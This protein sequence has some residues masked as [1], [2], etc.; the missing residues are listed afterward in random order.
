MV[1]AKALPMSKNRKIAEVAVPVP[2][3]NTFHYRVPEGLTDIISLGQRVLVPFGSRRLAGHVIGFPETSELKKLKE[4]G[5]I[6]DREPELIPDILELCRWASDYYVSP[7]GQVFKSALV[8]GTTQTKK[9]ACLTE[10]GLNYLEAG[11]ED[12]TSSTLRLIARRGSVPVQTLERKLGRSKLRKL[13]SEQLISLEQKLFHHPLK[14]KLL[15]FYRV[16]GETESLGGRAP[17]QNLLL[18]LIRSLGLVTLERLKEEEKSAP[19]LVRQLEEK[20]LVEK[21]LKAQLRQPRFRPYKGGRPVRLNQEQHQAVKEIRAALDSGCFSPFLLYGVTGSGKT[22][23]YMQAIRQTLAQGKG[24][25]FLLPEISLTPQVYSQVCNRF[26]ERVA[27]LHSGLSRGERFD[28]WRL[29]KQGRADIALGARSAI[30]APLRNLGLIIVDEEHEASYKQEGAFR[31]HARDLALIRAKRARALV[32]LGSAT[33][34]L[35]SFYNS[36]TKKS[37]PL[38]LKKRVEGRPMPEV[39]V[40]DMRHKGGAAKSLLSPRLF[41]ALEE[42]LAKGRQ[43]I[44]FLNRRGES[45]FVLCPECGF[46]YRCPYCSVSLVSHNQGSILRCHY[47]NFSLAL[48]ER[49][50]NCQGVKIRAFGAGCQQLERYVRRVFPQARVS[51]ADSDVAAKKGALE[52]VLADCYERKL[53][54][55]VGT[56]LIAHGLDF[57]GVDLVGVVAADTSLNFPDFRAGERTFQL[58]TQVAGRA[59]RVLPGQVIVQTYNPDHYAIRHA[60]RH[61]YLGFYREEIKFRK[62]LAYPPFCRL[63]KLDVSASREP[64]AQQTAQR[65][66]TLA[67][68]AIHLFRP[69][70]NS[71]AI[72]GPAPAPLA[73]LK[74]RYRWQLFL[75]GTRPAVLHSWLR[76]TIGAR[77]KEL[78]SQNPWVSVDVDPLSML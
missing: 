14:P 75:K 45:T 33:P 30:F 69:Q 17:K 70:D 51:R 55:L 78:S 40:V 27:L 67:E 25:I 10:K 4:V 34:A 64:A 56:Q 21:V 54:I 77:G 41:Q 37:L 13:E 35:E 62:E 2:V 72:L 57:P 1:V 22:E 7:L 32:I 24:V 71:L 23:V 66:K 50:P 44:L 18:G 9:S 6:L 38:I 58:L 29:I 65:L 42:T 20:G 73:R 52:A 53:D 12:E 19:R 15:A 39:V 26:G 49:C 5:E 46:A 76:K 68:E 43:A 16:K 11:Q 31:Y 48:K 63:V 8:Q 61:D 3:L 47:C 59:G 74:G 28:Q 36:Q 60:S